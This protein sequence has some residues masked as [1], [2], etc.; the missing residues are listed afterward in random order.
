MNEPDP[1][2][3]GDEPELP[4]SLAEDLRGAFRASDDVPSA[5]QETILGAVT[6]RAR[7]VRASR[8]RRRFRWIGPIATVAAGVLFFFLV[9]VPWARRGAREFGMPPKAPRVATY[10]EI[11]VLDAF[12]LARLLR[13]E[14]EHL[15]ERGWDLDESGTVDQGDVERLLDLAVR[16]EDA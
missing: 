3:A 16:L 11:D 10:E 8:L 1:I 2:R 14:N 15:L 5:V 12:Q 9:I 4:A 13:E 6:G 7:T